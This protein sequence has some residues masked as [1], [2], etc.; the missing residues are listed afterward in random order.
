MGK[1]NTEQ[2]KTS[3]ARI[4]TLEE[5]T[6]GLLEHLETERLF[7]RLDEIETKRDVHHRS[8]TALVEAARAHTAQLAD[9]EDASTRAR[10]T[11]GKITER[12]DGL[13]LW[14]WQRAGRRVTTWLRAWF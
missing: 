3:L 2:R 7:E 6:E 4:A 8:I 9:L 5:V 10:V 11:F 12:L 14:P 13:E 1:G